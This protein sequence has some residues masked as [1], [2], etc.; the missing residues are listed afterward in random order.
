MGAVGR[1]VPRRVDAPHG[2]ILSAALRLARRQAAASEALPS[3][4]SG[5]GLGPPPRLLSSTHQ[6]VLKRWF[7][8]LL[9][10]LRAEVC[11]ICPFST[12]VL[13]TP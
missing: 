3:H 12:K 6:S 4:G 9:G 2:L 13:S 8:R 11:F 5:A 1:K 7:S 10:H